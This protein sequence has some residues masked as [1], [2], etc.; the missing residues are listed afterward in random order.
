M[1]VFIHL[2]LSNLY[3]VKFSLLIEFPKVFYHVQW[4]ATSSRL[5]A[6]N[7]SLKAE[8]VRKFKLQCKLICLNGHYK[9]NPK[10]N[11]PGNG[12]C[13]YNLMSLL[14]LSVLGIYIEGATWLSIRTGL[15]LNHKKN[16][17]NYWWIQ[18][19]LLQLASLSNP[20]SE[21]LLPHE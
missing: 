18:T 11:I 2:V 5:I 7:C 1:Y 13:N 16:P 12:L 3:K 19:V 15:L 6:L 4:E 8:T 10:G 14:K 17:Y 20:G 21:A 9:Q